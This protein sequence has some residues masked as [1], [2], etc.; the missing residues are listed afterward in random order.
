MVITVSDVESDSQLDVPASPGVLA[1]PTWAF[2]EG[3]L[4]NSMIPGL[5]VP[6]K[7]GVLANRPVSDVR[8]PT[9]FSGSGAMTPKRGELGR[10]RPTLREYDPRPVMGSGK[11]VAS[12]GST[13]EY[14]YGCSST[15]AMGGGDEVYDDD[16]CEIRGLYDMEE[17]RVY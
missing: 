16:L 4:E 7:P 3:F 17:S 1:T 13:V 11:R 8:I 2:R 14:S 6:V 10:W 9:D 5:G 12:G 15:F